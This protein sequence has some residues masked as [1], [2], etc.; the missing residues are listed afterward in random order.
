MPD[1]APGFYWIR[2][3][4]ADGDDWTIGEYETEAFADDPWYIIGGD[5]PVSD[6]TL[7]EIGPRVDSPA[8]TSPD[9]RR[10]RADLQRAREDAD[11]LR[12]RLDYAY[13]EIRQLR[14]KVEGQVHQAAPPK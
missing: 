5:V 9:L 13:E 7:A 11:D 12:R 1:R 4:N 2:L 10:L 3:A 6:S 14:A 8:E